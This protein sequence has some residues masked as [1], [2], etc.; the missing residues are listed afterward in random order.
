MRYC[1]RVNPRFSVDLGY[2]SEF[3]IHFGRKLPMSYKLQLSSRASKSARS[4][5][6]DFQ[7]DGVKK[8]IF[9]LFGQHII[10]LL[11]PVKMMKLQIKMSLLDW[12]K[13]IGRPPGYEGMQ[14]PDPGLNQGPLDLQSN[15]LPTELSRPAVYANAE[16]TPCCSQFISTSYWSEFEPLNLWSIRGGTDREHHLSVWTKVLI[17]SSCD[18]FGTT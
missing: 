10:A 2:S 1:V 14:C 6:T 4:L 11:T 9:I 15:A 17:A 3:L 5:F 8:I 12:K 7:A 18:I 16:Q 13:N